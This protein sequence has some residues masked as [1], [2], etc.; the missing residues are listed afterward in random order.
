[1]PVELCS[2]GAVRFEQCMWL[3]WLGVCGCGDTCGCRGW[4]RLAATCGMHSVPCMAWLHDAWMHALRRPCAVFGLVGVAWCCWE[5]A[6]CWDVEKGAPHAGN[7]C[8]GP[9]GTHVKQ[10]ATGPGE[11][12]HRLE[13]GLARL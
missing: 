7:I 3:W 11:S 6:T 8:H 5:S 1:M 12:V 9:W 10:S 13:W 2:P 4:V